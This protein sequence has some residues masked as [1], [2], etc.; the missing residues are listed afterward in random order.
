MMNQN[1]GFIFRVS[2]IVFALIFSISS[3]NGEDWQQWRGPALNGSTTETGLPVTWSK[4]ENVRW[5]VKMPGP[6]PATPIIWKDRVFVTAAEAD[7]NRMWAI[8]L[9]RNDGSELWKHMVGIGFPSRNGNNGAS[10]SPVTD[11][12]YVYFLYGTGDM[13]AFDM[14]G[15][16]IWQRNIEEKHGKM[17]ISFG[18]GASPLLYEGKLYLSVLHRHTKVEPESGNPE[19]MSYLLCIDPKTGEDIWKHERETDAEGESMEAYTTPYPFVSSKGTVIILAGADYVTAHDPDDGREIWRTI[20]LNSEGRK[21]YRLVPSVVSSG[22]MVIF[23]EARGV[24]LFGMQ[25]DKTGQL[26]DEDIAWTFRENAPDVCTPLVMDDKLYVLD[27]RKRVMTC[28]EP[29]TGEVIWSEK[30]G[31]NKAF[32]TSPTG[33]DGKIYC[34]SMDG[35][36]VV[37]SAGDSFQIL[38][39]IDMGEGECRSTISA[40]YGN[41]FIRT[42]ENLYCIGN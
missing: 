18:Y 16:I 38:S 27:G 1:C 22:D 37:L 12:Q 24:A 4:T 32:Q 13:M 19:P 30:L 33:A 11:G 5:V 39:Q 6:G 36:V 14:D 21:N 3:A 28:L 29:S 2:F 20:K 25:G 17:W 31:I 23:Y 7:T 42:S 8:C 9:D 34:I 26:S 41:L 35:E 15:N 10:S 40:A